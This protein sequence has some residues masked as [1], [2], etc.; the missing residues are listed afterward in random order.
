MLGGPLC[1]QRDG[2]SYYPGSHLSWRYP[3]RRTS[4][5]SST[6]SVI[7]LFSRAELTANTGENNTSGGISQTSYTAISTTSTRGSLTV[8]LEPAEARAA[9]ALWKL[10]KRRELCH[11]RN[12]QEQPHTR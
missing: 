9:G 11:F 5:G 6:A 10:G 12:P 4:T 3:N 2:G 7:D 1:V 8:I